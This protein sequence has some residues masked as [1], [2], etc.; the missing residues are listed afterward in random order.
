MTANGTSA[1]AGTGTRIDWVDYA[2]GICIVMVVMMH[3]VLGV[4]LAAG[5]TGFMHLVVAFAKPFRMPDFFLISGLFLPLVIDRDWRTYLDRKVVHFAY[6]Y[7]LWVT[8]QFGFKAPGFAAETSWTHAGYLY[9]ESFIEPFGTLWF[10]YLLPIFF[11]VIKL[12]RRMPPSF[13]W[14]IAAGLEMAQIATGWTVIDEFCA[15]FVYIYSGYLFADQ[16]FALSERARARPALA[17]AGLIGWAAIDA[18]LVAVSASEWPL[19]SL[20]LGFAGACAIIVCGTLLAR[21]Q[22]LNGLRFCGEHSIVIYLAFF[23]PMAATRSALLKTGLIADIGTV[24]L[25]VTV[26]GVVGALVI[27]RLA[28]RLNADFL[29]E[30]PDPFWIAPR[31][32]SPAL[33]AAQ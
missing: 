28:L 31:R 2:K 10:I 23:L 3:S 5:K 30:R 19:I 13:L 32:P 4:E 18:T 17:I 12:T 33:Q 25:L 22:L 16:M 20:G 14:G 9:L 24:S 6:F 21:A 29:F 11:V 26:A 7:V 8:I 15:R 1:A 27:W